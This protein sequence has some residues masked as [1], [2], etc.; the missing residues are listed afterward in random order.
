MHYAF[1]V[2]KRKQVE[3]ALKKAHNELELKVDERTFDLREANEQLRIN[4]DT[5]MQLQDQLIRSERL[6]ATGQLAAS[7]A[8][9]INSPL[10]AVTSMLNTLK[11]TYKEDKNLLDNIDLL[12]VSFFSIRDTVK[13]LLDLNRPDKGRKKSANI[14]KIIED[15]VKLVRSHVKSSGIKLN[16]SLSTSVPD[17]TL[18]V[19][20][21]SQI[22]LNLINNAVEA[23]TGR[24]SS[25]N[26]EDFKSR[27]SIGGEL[28]IKTDYSGRDIIITVSDTGPGIS[29]KDLTHI[30]DPFYTKKKQMG[31][32][33]GLSICHA[34]IEDHKGT[35]EVKN[36]PEGGAI[37]TITLSVS[38][39]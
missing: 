36:S 16:L 12:K 27:K 15:T 37:F 26:K 20:Q 14:N 34:I 5:Q 25:K 11:E 1:D 39:K 21:M 32:G 28:T 23:M 4:A 22:F 10:Q 2:T 6:A 13:H 30:F 33:I 38:K 7:V 18:S 17:S 35:I 8:H 19:Q 9:E 31:M 3:E 29:K 24:L